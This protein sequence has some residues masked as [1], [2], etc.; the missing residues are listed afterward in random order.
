[1]GAASET[2]SKH[3]LLVT[4]VPGP[5]IPVPFPKQGG[6]TLSEVHMVFPNVVPQ[7]SF[8]SY[9]GFVSANLV[10]DPALF[11]APAQFAQCYVSAFQVLQ[12]DLSDSDQTS[13][14]LLG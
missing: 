7:V 5:T 8:I 6:E 13:T 12:E 1:M 9:N 3:S 10:A 14:S 2:F 4:N 11:S